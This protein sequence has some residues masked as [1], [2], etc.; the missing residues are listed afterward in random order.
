M[1]SV[2]AYCEEFGASAERG[3]FAFG[4]PLFVLAAGIGS[5]IG[6]SIEHQRAYENCMT[7][8]GYIRS[9]ASVGAETD[10]GTDRGVRAAPGFSAEQSVATPTS[11]RTVRYKRYKLGE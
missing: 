2:R 11:V 5:L 10:A 1:E 7:V 3:S 9:A 6:N 8:H 4:S